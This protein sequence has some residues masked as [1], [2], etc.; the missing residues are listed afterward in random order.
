MSNIYFDACC[1]IDLIKWSAAGRAPA[2]R[3]DDI[4]Y[5]E[6]LIDASKAKEVIVHTSFLT[7]AEATHIRADDNSRILTDQVKSKIESL[8]LSGN[9]PVRAIQPS[10]FVLDRI[11]EMAWQK[12][13][14]L[15]GFDSLHVASAIEAECKEFLTTD[16]R[17]GADNRRKLVDAYGLTVCKPTETKLLPE[18][19]KQSGFFPGGK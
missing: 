12:E 15:K 14:F 2:D 17:I 10:I 16:D 9:S 5:C 18:K 13:I 3:Q 11:R 7:F 6:K 19:Y 4:W 1:F 8:L